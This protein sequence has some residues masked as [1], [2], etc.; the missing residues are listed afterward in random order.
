MQCRDTCYGLV[1]DFEMIVPFL[2]MIILCFTSIHYVFGKYFSVLKFNFFSLIGS[3]IS[4]TGK[5]ASCHKKAT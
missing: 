4:P 3:I 2:S 5:L 1:N